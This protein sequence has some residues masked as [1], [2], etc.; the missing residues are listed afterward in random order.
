MIPLYLLL[1]SSP[2]NVGLS[3]ESLVGPLPQSYDASANRNLSH[4]YCFA[5]TSAQVLPSDTKEKL[6]WFSN[7]SSNKMLSLSAYFGEI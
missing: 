7:V 2:S 4:P 5:F 3:Q 6:E 1:S